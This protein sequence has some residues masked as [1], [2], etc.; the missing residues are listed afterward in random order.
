MQ[1]AKLPRSVC[2]NIDKKTRRFLWEG[3]EEK[4]SVHLLSWETIQKPRSLGGLGIRSSSQA[5]AAFL[6]K[7]GWRMLTEP[8]SLWARVLR[9]KYCNGRC[10]ID[11]FQPKAN[12][13]N[14]WAG[15]TKQANFISRGMSFAIGNGRRTLFWDHSWV[16]VGCLAD[17]VLAPI[18]ESILGATVSDMWDADSGWKWD[19]FANFLPQVELLKIASYFLSPEPDIE[20]ELY[21]NGSAH[22]KFTIKSALVI[23]KGIDIPTEPDPVAWHL[24]WKLPV[25]QRIRMF[26]WLAAHDRLMTNFNRVRR[27]LAD[28]S[29]C[30]RCL[31]EEE[32]TDHLLRHCP[33]SVE[34]WSHLGESTSSGLFFTENFRL[35]ISTN[36]SNS[37]P[38]ASSLWSMKFAITCWWIW[39]WRNN[40]VFGRTED[41]P[42]DP[43]FFLYRQFDLSK[44]AFDPFSLFIPSPSSTRVERYIRWHPPPH[45]WF[46]LN[47]DGASRGNPGLAGCGGIIRNDAE[48]FVSAFT[49]SSGICTSMRAEMR[50]LVVGLEHAR[51]LGLTNLLV[52]MD[53]KACVD[54]FRHEQLLSNSLRPLVHRS[55]ELIA[56]EGWEVRIDHTYREANRAADWLANLGVRSAPNTTIFGTPPAELRSILREDILG[57]SFP[58]LVIN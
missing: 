25:Q 47:T 45:N 31:S 1:T 42:T 17:R 37:S 52:H 43:I 41:N 38:F 30:P 58:R 15:I 11:M 9:A 28:D 48:N 18:P 49:F 16:D 56:L 19:E 55:R 8:S 40:I 4:K 50:A 23:L 35:W 3:N 36:A 57:V 29:V 13:S 5:N 44:Q 39:R 46:L 24:I 7:L 20:D 34:I 2:D 10:D 51:S 54:F 53:N 14:V 26:I 12:M 21:W 22:G 32:T 33:T 6:M 27:G